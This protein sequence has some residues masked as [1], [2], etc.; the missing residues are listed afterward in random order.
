MATG[1][2]LKIVFW[3]QDYGFP[4]PNQSTSSADFVN[5]LDLVDL[6]DHVDL[7]DLVDHLDLVDLLD[8]FDLVNLVAHGS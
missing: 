7:V 1:E 4:S 8:L 5:L 6:V 3:L 2:S